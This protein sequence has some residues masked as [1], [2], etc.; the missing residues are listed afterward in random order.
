M[1]GKKIP[2]E[3]VMTEGVVMTEEA[4]MT[5]AAVMT[6]EAVMT[7]GVVMTVL[8][9]IGSAVNAA[10]PTSHFEPNAI[11]VMPPSQVAE[12]A[13][14]MNAVVAVMSTV[15]AVMTEVDKTAP[16]EIGIALSATTP[17]FHFEPNAI[18]AMLQKEEAG[19]VEAQ[20]VEKVE[21]VA[22]SAVVNVV[23]PIK[24]AMIEGI[25]TTVENAETI[26]KAIMT[27]PAHNAIIPT[28]HSE[29]NVTAVMHPRMEAVAREEAQE[30]VTEVA[31][32]VETEVAQE[33]VTEVAQ[34][35]VT[36]AAQEVAT[37]EPQEA[38]AVTE[39]PQEA[40]AVTEV[41]TEA[42]QEVATETADKAVRV[43]MDGEDLLS[44][45]HQ[46]GFSDHGNLKMN[47]DIIVIEKIQVI[48]LI[49]TIEEGKFH[50]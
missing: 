1:I 19:I 48:P 22:V 12:M 47:L 30:A 7:E 20:E 23:A 13:A 27:G 41:E 44:V 10:T 39:E 25:E 28:S 35:V 9:E 18:A 40:E 8:V 16:V 42:A 14:V 36:E 38:E 32:E 49:R 31:Q 21:A 6:E 33:A 11:A 3:V 34:E 17:T 29:P 50:G 4:V 46:A 26:T 24:S 2:E 15:V 43:E 45:V 37:E 5:E